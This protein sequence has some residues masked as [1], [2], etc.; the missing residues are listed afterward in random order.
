M[1][2]G[3]FLFVPE[4]SSPS[5]FASFDTLYTK[6]LKYSFGLPKKTWT[7]NL[8]RH[9]LVPS[10]QQNIHIALARVALSTLSHFDTS[11]GHSTR[12]EI[13]RLHQIALSKL[14]ITNFSGTKE[15]RLLCVLNNIRSISQFPVSIPVSWTLARGEDGHACIKFS[16]GCLDWHQAQPCTLCGARSKGLAHLFECNSIPIIARTSRQKASDLLLSLGST[17]SSL[18]ILNCPSAI[19]L[20]C[21]QPLPALLELAALLA[22]LYTTSMRAIL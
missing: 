1:L 10:A 20:C 11:L 2:Y 14:T 4:L 3:G 21:D 22:T 13:E 18:D 5:I 9:F 15:T 6:T 16:L 8:L 19:S 17:L 7:A 12:V